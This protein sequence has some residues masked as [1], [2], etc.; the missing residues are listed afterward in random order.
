M[1]LSYI[2][3][4]YLAQISAKNL[5]YETKLFQGATVVYE[6]YVRPYISEHEYEIDHTLLEFRARASDNALVAQQLVASYLKTSLS[7]MVKY[8]LL[9][10]PAQK[11][12]SF[13]V[14]FVA[15]ERHSFYCHESLFPL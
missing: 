6:K 13:Q 10:M 1:S 5:S 2:L 15:K 4:S 3:S 11:K 8:A 7:E 9:L 14:C 12:D